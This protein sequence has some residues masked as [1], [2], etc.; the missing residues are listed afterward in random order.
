MI[1]RKRLLVDRETG[2]VKEKG[3][4]MWVEGEEGRGEK[5]RD[6]RKGSGG[7]KEK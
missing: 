2:S 4:G 7:R 1:P 3:E 6:E 5:G